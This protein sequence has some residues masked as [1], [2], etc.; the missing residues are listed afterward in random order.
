[1]LR[2]RTVDGCLT[3]QLFEHFGSTSESITRFTDRDV[4]DKLLDAEF[5]HRV[6][7]FVFRGLALSRLL[8]R[9]W[10]Y[11]KE[12]VIPLSGSHF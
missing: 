6:C 12:L 3:T 4:K 9:Y 8:I 10:S 1:M 7:G 2:R 5:A 11:T